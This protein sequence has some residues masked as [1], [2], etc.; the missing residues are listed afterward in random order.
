ML[1][2]F[3]A[4]THCPQSANASKKKNT[5]RNSA[6]SPRTHCQRCANDSKQRNH[7]LSHALTHAH[8]R[9]RIHAHSQTHPLTHT[10]TPMQGIVEQRNAK[11][12]K[13][14]IARLSNTK[15]SNA[16]TRE[17]TQ[18]KALQHINT[19]TRINNKQRA[20]HFTTPRASTQ[21]NAHANNA[22]TTTTTT[23]AT[24]KR[25]Y[26]KKHTAPRCPSY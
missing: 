4:H 6:Q 18:R 20:Y 26:Q 13:A 11:Q 24:T 14:T 22:P 15:Q 12:C 17:A 21:R 16:T 23:H 5:R 10:R 19:A 8:T 2:I 7:T 25:C 3:L 1:P 9:T